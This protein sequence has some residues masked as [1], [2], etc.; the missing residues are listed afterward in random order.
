MKEAGQV[1]RQ[2]MM[3]RDSEATKRIQDA[4]VELIQ[5]APE[6]REQFRQLSQQ[7]HDKFSEQVGKDYL[8][9]LKAELARGR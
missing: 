6:A 2:A 9:R 7:V 3:Q 4:G 5:L 8:D 1:E